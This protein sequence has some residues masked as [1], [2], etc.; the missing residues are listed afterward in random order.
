[1]RKLTLFPL[2]PHPDDVKGKRTVITTR[3]HSTERVALVLNNLEDRATQN[4]FGIIDAGRIV[5]SMEE[6]FDLYSD[7]AVSFISS[8]G[9]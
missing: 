7:R 6:F 5:H 3:Y 1:M 8:D 2:L 4:V 9:D